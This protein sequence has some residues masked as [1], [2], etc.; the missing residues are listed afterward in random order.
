MSGKTKSRQAARLPDAFSSNAVSP[1]HVDAPFSTRRAFVVQFRTGGA[2]LTGRV[3][4]MASGEAALFSD[5]HELCGFF[6]RVLKSSE[7]DK[8]RYRND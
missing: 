5:L 7:A 6:D 2:T 3:E 8:K 1:E 4:H